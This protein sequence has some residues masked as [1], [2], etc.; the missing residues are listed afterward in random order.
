MGSVPVPGFLVFLKKTALP[1]LHRDK[2]GCTSLR[3]NAVPDPEFNVKLRNLKSNAVP[4]PEFNVTL[5]SLKPIDL[6]RG[7]VDHTSCTGL[8]KT[9]KTESDAVPEPE[10]LISVRKVEILLVG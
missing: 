9:G 8:K 7:D 4:D 6:F 5:R 10:L 1:S 3:S 2:V